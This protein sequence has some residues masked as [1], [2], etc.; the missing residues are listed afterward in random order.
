M[1]FTQNPK[2]TLVSL[3]ILLAISTGQAFA[4]PGGLNKDGCHSNKITG[5]YHCHGLS[6]QQP[7]NTSKPSQLS[8]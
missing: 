3:A 2:R 6:S 5:E 7:A 4:H 8:L 1:L